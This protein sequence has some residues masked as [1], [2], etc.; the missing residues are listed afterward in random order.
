[1]DAAKIEHHKSTF[2]NPLV[3]PVLVVP[4]Q[5][6]PKTFIDNVVILLFDYEKREFVNALEAAAHLGLSWSDR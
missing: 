3:I 1:M 5:T 4:A 6:E 2:Q